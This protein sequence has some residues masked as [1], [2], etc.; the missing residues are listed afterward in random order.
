[1]RIEIKK[2]RDK[3]YASMIDISKYDKL[4]GNSLLIPTEG[5]TSDRIIE[6][7]LKLKYVYTF[8]KKDTITTC[9]SGKRDDTSAVYA[10]MFSKITEDGFE[11]EFI[12]CSGTFR[13]Q[14]G[15]Y[16][17]RLVLYKNI[18]EMYTKFEDIMQITDEITV[19][20][21][22]EERLELEV[23]FFFPTGYPMIKQFTESVDNLRLAIKLFSFSWFA[24]FK[25]IHEKIMENHM[26]P[27][28]QYLIYEKKD[29]PKFDMLMEKITKN[30][31]VYNDVRDYI[32]Q[33]DPER[34]IQEDV[35]SREY[36]FKLFPV[37]INE[38]RSMEFQDINYPIWREL[39]ITDKCANLALNFI[40]PMF[41]MNGN[42]FFIQNSHRLAFDNIAQHQKFEASDIAEKMKDELVLVNKQ[43]YT[44]DDNPRNSKFMKLSN[45]IK[46]SIEYA[47][48]SLILTDLILCS[49]GEYIGR[50]VFDSMNLVINNLEY[51]AWADIYSSEV[52]F[53][54]HIFEFLYGLYCA[55]TRAGIMN[56]DIHLNNCTFNSVYA[57][58]KDFPKK[59]LVTYI[60]SADEIYMFEH[61]GTFSGIIDFSRSIVGSAESLTKDYDE[62]FA[63]RY[64]K[65]Q[66]SRCM[67]M[68]FQYFQD[69]SIKHRKEL[70]AAMYDRF[71]LMFKIMSV[72][73]I[74]SIVESLDRLMPMQF[75]TPE[76]KKKL[77]PDILPFVSKVAKRTRE[78]AEELL[79][80][81]VTGKIMSEKDIEWPNLVL[82]REFFQPIKSKY[83]D[84]DGKSVIVDI[85]DYTNKLQYDLLSPEKYPYFLTAKYR[86]E[87]YKKYGA[88]DKANKQLDKSE[89]IEKLGK[90]DDISKFIDKYVKD[91]DNTHGIPASENKTFE[92]MLE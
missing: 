15:E 91:D 32:I 46:F 53:K 34:A 48:D 78:F 69:F 79:T 18:S 88:I 1:M 26:N 36:G 81:V 68:L 20:K 71:P 16:R 86:A 41:P 8:D 45:K 13:S 37:T 76:A 19:D 28:Y 42:W 58:P 57:V 72:F 61:S 6:K 92:W 39:Y 31:L 65:N 47:K 74:L 62:D 23:M 70:T 9:F 49:T 25:M 63:E 90:L 29:I 83:S 17:K 77:H 22:S 35:I 80:K 33:P 67:H 2:D 59:T 11:H 3:W 85:F 38:A 14:D 12:S 56:G 84:A 43:A 7:F 40:S 54:K 44:E 27:A 73:D 30:K 52:V 55:N 50:T 24:D 51:A 64:M 87:M 21:I 89:R 75:S 60:L 82:L 66:V 5:A 10:M 4:K